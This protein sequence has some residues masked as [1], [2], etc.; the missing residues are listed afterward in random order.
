M[1]VCIRDRVW[2]TC[3]GLIYKCR[4]MGGGTLEL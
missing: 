2:G 4:G 1:R 3:F